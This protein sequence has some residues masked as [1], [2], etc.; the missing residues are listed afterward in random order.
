MSSCAKYIPNTLSCG[1][2]PHQDERLQTIRQNLYPQEVAVTNQFALS[3]DPTFYYLPDQG[4][5]G[6]CDPRLNSPV[7]GMKTTLSRPPLKV[8]V[9]CDLTNIDYAGKPTTYNRIQDIN[10]GD[11]IYYYN[12]FLA[13]PYIPINFSI[14]TDINKEIFTDP[15]TSVKPQYYREKNIY[16]VGCNQPTRDTLAFR[17]D[18][19]ERFLRKSNQSNWQVFY[20]K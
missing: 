8:D 15:M 17:E 18:M 12:K 20:S 4:C 14:P 9:N 16:S 2:I 10:V 6:S 5:W 1:D 7:L 3:P 13:Q 11:S 19:T